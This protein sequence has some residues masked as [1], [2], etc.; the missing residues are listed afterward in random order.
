[1]CCQR[2][3]TAQA[4]LR[5]VYHPHG[6]VATDFDAAAEKH[7]NDPMNPALADVAAALCATFIPALTP[8]S[9]VRCL[10]AWDRGGGGGR[11]DC[12]CLSFAIAMVGGE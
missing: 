12:F 9:K 7:K 8:G 11:V 1:M 3:S 6:A 2:H 10:F 5:S 4:I